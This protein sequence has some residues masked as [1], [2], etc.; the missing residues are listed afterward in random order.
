MSKEHRIPLGKIRCMNKD[1]YKKLGKS[2]IDRS[3]CS[4]NPQSTLDK[5][6]ATAARSP[7]TQIVMKNGLK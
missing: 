4:D 1:C 3:Y 5:E 7:I 2:W 6:I